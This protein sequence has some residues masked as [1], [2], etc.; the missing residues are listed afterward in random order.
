MRKRH[1]APVDSVLRPQVEDGV[2]SGGGGGPLSQ[3]LLGF[4]LSLLLQALRKSKI[5]PDDPAQLEL[6][7]PFLPQL[8]RAMRCDDDAVVALALRSLSAML[9]LPIRSLPA[10]ATV[11]LDRTLGLLK[12][13]ANFRPLSELVGV[14]VKVLT[15]LLR[16]PPRDTAADAAHATA[17]GGGAAAGF[18][19]APGAGG[20]TVAAAD[21]D[22][23][24]GDV[25]EGGD[26]G[27]LLTPAQG[28]DG[29]P[30]DRMAGGGARLAEPQLR[31]LLNFVSIHL[32]D[33]TMQPSLFGLMRTILVRPGRAPAVPL[34]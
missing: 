33:S 26:G 27:G 29:L 21:A 4:A 32:D 20:E 19:N 6:M 5:D 11:L 34:Q 9:R 2:T 8:Q 23:A 17:T 18:S 24:G 28:G 3:E 16:K 22:V 13:S 25:L 15:A 10:H 31:W 1:A 14:C 12:R 7:E 30:P